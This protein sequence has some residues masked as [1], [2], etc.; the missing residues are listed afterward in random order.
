MLMNRLV[1]I[2]SLAL[3]LAGGVAVAD[4][5]KASTSATFESLDRDKDQQ[6]S[7]SEASVN[8]DVSAHFAALDANTDGFLTKREF[9]A[10]AKMKDTPTKDMPKQPTQ[11]DTPRRY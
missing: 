8:E 2:S 9:G 10:H 11:E 7:R 3:A 4:C 6:V 5:S 1:L